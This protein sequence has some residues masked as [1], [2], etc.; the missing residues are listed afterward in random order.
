MQAPAGMGDAL[1]TWFEAEDCRLK[2]TGN[3][4]GRPGA[5]AAHA[6]ARLCYETLLE[7]GEHALRACER[8]VVTPALER[9]IA[10]VRAEDVRA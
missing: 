9:V 3:M 2:G 8:G 7:F 4:T 1:S 5:A 6:L 10:S